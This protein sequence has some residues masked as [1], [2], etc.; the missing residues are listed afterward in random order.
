[1]VVSGGSMITNRGGADEITVGLGYDSVL[2]SSEVNL[3]AATTIAGGLGS[4]T[5][6]MTA[7]ATL[8]DKIGRAS[9]RERVQGPVG[10]GTVIQ[11]TNVMEAGSVNV[12]TGRRATSITTSQT[13]PSCVA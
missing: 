7:A 3:A 12:T 13:A 1:M 6:Q 10:A 9:C 8:T 5:I 2:F 4:D 11:S